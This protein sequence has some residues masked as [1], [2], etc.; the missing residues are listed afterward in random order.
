MLTYEFVTCLQ[1]TSGQQNK[2]KR[3]TNVLNK[4][5]IV[6]SS[7]R[8]PVKDAI[9]R[10]LNSVKFTQCLSYQIHFLPIS[11]LNVWL[12]FFNSFSENSLP[13]EKLTFLN[14][15]KNKENYANCELII[16]VFLVCLNSVLRSNLWDLF[17]AHTIRKSPFPW[18]TTSRRY[19]YKVDCVWCCMIAAHDLVTSNCTA[20]A[21]TEVTSGP[22]KP[23]LV[24][25]GLP[26][27]RS[28]VAVTRGRASGKSK[29]RHCVT[30]V[31]EYNH[32]VSTT[33][34]AVFTTQGYMEVIICSC[35]ESDGRPSCGDKTVGGQTIVDVVIWGISADFWRC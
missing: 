15:L 11:I 26:Q 19:H 33:W 13:S 16:N 12:V 30:W 17:F 35:S 21:C 27:D 5:V 2:Q 8:G 25:I 32:V 18:W 3:V 20:P 34:A 24:K 7:H 1:A 4:N 22:R 29:Q 9:Q 31:S 23:K 6:N 10:F 28:S 14:K